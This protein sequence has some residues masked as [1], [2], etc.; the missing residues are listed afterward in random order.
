MQVVKRD[1]TEVELDKNKI[2]EA[3]KY[4]AEGIEGVSAQ[5][6]AMNAKLSLY[7]GI[8]T[9][10]IHNAIVTSAK[11]MISEL[12]DG[13]NLLAGRLMLMQLRKE[14]YG[15][16]TPPH[17]GEHIKDMC[18]RGLYHEDILKKWT[19]RDFEYFNKRIDHECDLN[20]NYASMVQWKEK[21]LTQNRVTKEVYET[22]QMAL[23]VLSM[24]AYEGYPKSTRKQHAMNLYHALRDMK[25]SMPTPIMA[26]LRGPM[27]QFSSCVLIDVDDNL[28]SIN[29]A[30]SA[31]V[32]Y[33]AQRAGIGINGGRIRSLGSPV[34]DGMVVHTGAIGFWKKFLASLSS[35]SQGGVRK[36]SA[37][38]F[39]PYWHKDVE[40]F[41]VLKNN[42]GIEENRIRHLDYGV[43]FNKLFL[44]KAL[45]D[46]QLNLFCPNDVPDMYEAFFADQEKFELLYNQYSERSDIPKKTVKAAELLATFFQERSSTGRK[47]VQFVDHCNNAGPFNPVKAPIKQSNLCLEIALPTSPLVEHQPEEGEIAL[48]TLAAFNL[49]AIEEEEIDHLSDVIVRTIDAL[50]DYQEYPVKAAEKAKLRRSIGTGVV[51][52]A[53][54]IAKQGLKYSD[55][56]ALDATHK[57]FEKIQYSLLNASAELA[58]E[59]GAC[60]YFDDTRYAD[61]LLPIDWYNKNVDKVCN[62]P[63]EQDWE[64]LREK[65]ADY[66]LRNSTLT[67]LMPSET[68]SLISGAT[69]GIEPIRAL[70]TTKQSK[71]GVFKFVAPEVKELWDKYELVWDIPSNEGYLNLVAVMQKFV[72]QA[73]SANTNYKP[74][75]YPGNKV[76]YNI[77]VKDLVEAYKKGVKTLYY[78]NTYDG[79]GEEIEDDGC[80][81]GACKI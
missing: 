74:S 63:L 41:L 81:S 28:S 19:E 70:T 77:L 29:A 57:L 75:N 6:V 1:G 27:K 52:Y 3:I 46:E 24:C 47:Y 45:K 31:I 72:D 60:E 54:W 62:T 71:D 76:P 51:N 35:C 18:D 43:Q 39:Y 66:G 80:S 36:G 11:D 69:N 2:L 34:R 13:Y 56:S 16:Y 10:E 15:E 73:I 61:G 59:L 5:V 67:A 53:K 79:S 32:H 9:R 37:T 48:C 20:Y 68:S 49:G 7:E 50:F 8:S 78:H 23:M 21:Y 65:I 44:E 14:A 12:Q 40:S 42:K 58:G 25:I 4:C 26:G 64:A 33:A 55:G 17:L 30:S 38:L 22:P